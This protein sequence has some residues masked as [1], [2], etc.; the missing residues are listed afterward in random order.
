MYAGNFDAAAE[1]ARQ[2]LKEDQKFTDAYVPLA[3]ALTVKGDRRGAR[4]TWEQMAGVAPGAVSAASMGLADL[5]LVEGLWEAAERR[6]TGSIAADEAARNSLGRGSKLVALAEA[7][8]AQGK[9]AAGVE[10]ARK[11]LASTH[12]EFVAIP[13]ARVLAANG[14]A[15]DAKA[16]AAELDKNLQTQTRAYAQ[17]I[18]GEIA[19]QQD[20]LN[21][22]VQAFQTAS[23]QYDVWLSHF[24]LGVAYVRAGHFT[25][26]LAEFDRC[27]KRRGEAT[28]LF[29]DDVPTLR[30]L[31]RLYYWH[32]RAQEAI[33][34]KG[35]ATENYK[36]Y[37]AI[38]SAATKDPLAIDA[39]QRVQSS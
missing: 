29:L 13:A 27:A 25:E 31:V 2:L 38:R 1:G 35:A 39:Q 17:I 26:A 28:A 4:R 34:M 14:R 9:I 30:Y 22:A 18:E 16:L 7:Y 8:L 3:I 20:R 24:N 36:A 15:A 33:G 10:A 12:Q 19:L 11:A 32:G 37:L 23:R 21:E 5:D 6:L